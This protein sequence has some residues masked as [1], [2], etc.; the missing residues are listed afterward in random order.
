MK[1]ILYIHGGGDVIGGIENHILDS[2]KHHIRFEG[3]VA[4][5]KDGRFLEL[6][7]QNEIKNYVCLNGGKMRNIYKSAKAIINCLKY[8]RQYNIKIVVANGMHSWIY[9]AIISKIS[10]IKSV[11]YY[12]NEIGR[13][14]DNLINEIGLLFTPDIAVANSCYTANSIK[15]I[16]KKKIEVVYPSADDKKISCIDADSSRRLIAKEF[17][18]NPE[19]FVF[20]VIGRIQVWKGQDVVIKAFLKLSARENAVLLIVGD[21]TF[22]KDRNYYEYLMSISK[23]NKSIIFTGHRDDVPAI[24]KASDAIV[25]AT[26]T[27]EPFGVVIVESMIAR[28]PVIATSIGGPSELIRNN[29]SGLLYKPGSVEELVKAMS[30]IQEDKDLRTDLCENAYSDYYSKFSFDVSMQKLEN[31]M[32]THLDSNSLHTTI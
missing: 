12:T 10:G 22:E 26:I 14:L 28:K 4:I 29:E 5:V 25:H 32:T 9:A 11:C 16:I 13:G 3:H 31:I 19:L 17:N 21:I 20:S 2:L 30:L 18:F 6:I 27:A 8:I 23:N 1:R 24:I 7:K 15:N